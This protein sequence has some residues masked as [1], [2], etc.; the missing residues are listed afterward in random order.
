LTA[1]ATAAA[2][3]AGVTEVAEHPFLVDRVA[4]P[5]R[6]SRDGQLDAALLGPGRLVEMGSATLAEIRTQLEPL[7]PHAPRLALYL[8]L[9][10]ERP[11]WNSERVRTV[12]Q[13]L[14]RRRTF[15][16]FESVE[17]VAEGH[18][19]GLIALHAASDRLRA[20]VAD[21]CVIAGFDSYLTL[22]TLEWL[23]RN[24]QLAT[25][26]HRGAFFPGEGAGAFAIAREST[27]ERAASE[28]LAA[29]RGVG[30]AVEANRIKTEAICLGEGLTAS[31]KTAV[32]SI[33]PPEE[34]VD[35][36]IC[37]ING[38]RYRNEE[39]AFTLL[40]LPEALADP[41]AYDAPASWWGDVGAASGPLFVVLA[42][43]AGR[44]GWAKGS[45]YL[46]WNSSEGGRRAAAL[47]QLPRALE[48]R[49]S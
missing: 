14:D 4:E 22:E 8:A 30:L 17:I 2:V 42:A 35:G 29:V 10:E 25:S 6:V 45:R 40:R 5:I 12:R 36:I 33:R 18:A 48:G 15:D 23:D 1:E 13:G 43:L 27:I 47:L 3:R 37:D 31:V 26:Y 9:A 7:R 41:T 16:E 21:V 32:A 38:E 28:A 19:A 46:V 20:G 24:R 49:A 39:W 11:G 34:I 44:R